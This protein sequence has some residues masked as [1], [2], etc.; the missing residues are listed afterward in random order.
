VWLLPTLTRWGLGFGTLAAP[1]CAWD[2]WDE[3]KDD[4]SGEHAEMMLLTRRSD[5]GRSAWLPR[6]WHSI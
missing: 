5:L 3:G 4:G 2:I 1:D 6:R